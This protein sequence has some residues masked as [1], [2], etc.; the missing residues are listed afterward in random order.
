M[1]PTERSP[2][3]RQAWDA[4]ARNFLGDSPDWYK[5]TIVT[6]IPAVKPVVTG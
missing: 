5:A 3:V 2:R 4:L 6:A 1:T